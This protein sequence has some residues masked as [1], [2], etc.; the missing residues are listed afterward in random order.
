MINGS[1]TRSGKPL[2]IRNKRNNG[3]HSG[4]GGRGKPDPIAMGH[5]V[6]FGGLGE[7]F[8]NGV[9]LNRFEVS[10]LGGQRDDPAEIRP[11]AGLEGGLDEQVFL[12]VVK[13]H[14]RPLRWDCGHSPAPFNRRLGGN[15]TAIPPRPPAAPTPTGRAQTRA[16]KIPE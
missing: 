8:K 7:V 1:K 13:D 16:A 6:G 15:D 11:A 5:H 10:R 3:Q 9:I 14:N 12:A 4:G 2:K